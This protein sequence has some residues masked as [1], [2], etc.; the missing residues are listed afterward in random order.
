VRRAIERVGRVAR[1]APATRI[2]HFRTV[3]SWL[4]TMDDWR[5]RREAGSVVVREGDAIAQSYHDARSAYIPSRFPGRLSLLRSE[6]GE[7]DPRWRKVAAVV[8][9]AVLPGSHRTC[10]TTD[11][12]V[13]CGHLIRVMHGGIGMPASS[14]T[15]LAAPLRAAAA[16]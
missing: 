3:R 5:Q 15:A 11:L 2:R 10:L 6:A 14:P 16:E 8:D 4:N 12:E 1:W 7:F 13:V 9:T